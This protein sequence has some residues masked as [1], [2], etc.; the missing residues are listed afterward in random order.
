MPCIGVSWGSHKKETLY[1]A[2]DQVPQPSTLDP[3]KG[4][5]ICAFD[6]ETKIRSSMRE[7]LSLIFCVSSPCTQSDAELY[8]KGHA[9]SSSDFEPRPIVCFGIFLTQ[10]WTPGTG[11]MQC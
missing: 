9:L 7:L 5:L 2:F 4:T 6:H 3:E 8:T 10:L 11:R 1:P